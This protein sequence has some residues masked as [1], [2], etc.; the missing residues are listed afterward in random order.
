MTQKLMYNKLFHRWVCGLINGQR[1]T[2]LSDS[3]YEESLWVQKTQ[4]GYQ[5]HTTIYF[6]MTHESQ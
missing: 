3:I 2:P 1:L 5:A 4:D 6:L